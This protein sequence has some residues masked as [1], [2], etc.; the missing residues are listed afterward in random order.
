MLWLTGFGIAAILMAVAAA[1]VFS[2]VYINA[3]AFGGLADY[4]KLGIVAFGSTTLTGA[5]G[6]LLT[7]KRP[8]DAQEANLLS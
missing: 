8:H 2:A 1:T 4:L 7:L 6:I 5:A 3:E